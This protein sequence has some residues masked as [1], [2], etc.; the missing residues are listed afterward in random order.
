M[1]F[2]GIVLIIYLIISIIIYIIGFLLSM[3]QLLDFYT[4]HGYLFEENMGFCV[5]NEDGKVKYSLSKSFRVS[6][7]WFSP[8]IDLITF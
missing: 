5:K 7:L 2:V 8:I 6:F 3:L 1:N 4:S